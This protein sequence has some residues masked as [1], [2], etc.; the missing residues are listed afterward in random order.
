MATQRVICD[1]C[2]LRGNALQLKLQMFQY[3]LSMGQA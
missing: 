3:L 1:K 2:L